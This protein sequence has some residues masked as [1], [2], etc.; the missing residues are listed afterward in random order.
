MEGNFSPEFKAFT[1]LPLLFIYFLSWCVLSLPC[2]LR[3]CIL[4]EQYLAHPQRKLRTGLL[5]NRGEGIPAHPITLLPMGCLQV[6]ADN[7]IPA[8]SYCYTTAK[9]ALPPKKHIQHPLPHYL[10]T[11]ISYKTVTFMCFLKLLREGGL[12]CYIPSARDSG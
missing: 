8:I 4:I 10:Y 12:S 9:R 11:A 1:L 7:S 6:T 5:G 2:W 3:C